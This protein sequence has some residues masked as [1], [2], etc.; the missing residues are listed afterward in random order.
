MIRYIQNPDLIG[1]Q[2]VEES[3]QVLQEYPYFEAAHLL[4]LKSVKQTDEA[5]YQEVLPKHICHVKN[6]KSLFFYSEGSRYP[7]LRLCGEV[8][9]EDREDTRKQ[10]AVE[11]ID[12]FLEAY[13]ADK[14]KQTEKEK[15][16]FPADFVP[17]IDYSY[18]VDKTTAAVPRTEYP[19]RQ[20]SSNSYQDRLID[21]FIE[22]VALR[23]KPFQLA[24]EEH[25]APQ[26]PTESEQAVLS[27]QELP[28]SE[29]TARIYIKQHRYEEALQI[30]QKLSLIYPEKNIYF[31]DQIR[32]L[33]KLIININSK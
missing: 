29:D 20:S 28:L 30:I 26:F 10:D 17:V 14:K 27:D 19:E 16:S 2:S 5:R 11:M 22:E 32:F 8:A 23:E 4:Y 7:W 33:R 1:S 18:L 15:T 31:A 6:N 9:K 3:E 12:S 13:R 24:A 25:P 21:R